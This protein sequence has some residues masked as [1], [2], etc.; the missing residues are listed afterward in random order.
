MENPLPSKGHENYRRRTSR[1]IEQGN[2]YVELVYRIIAS[3]RYFVSMTPTEDTEGA[4]D[5]T[6]LFGNELET[7]VKSSAGN[8]HS[9]QTNRIFLHSFQV[10]VDHAFQLPSIH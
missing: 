4:V 8:Q 7:A 3:G 6:A 9:W 1:G 2:T 5:A 10:Q